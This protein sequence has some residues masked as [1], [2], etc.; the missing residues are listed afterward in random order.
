MRIA[1]ACYDFTGV[2]NTF[3]RAHVDRLSDASCVIA[4]GLPRPLNQ[5]ILATLWRSAPKT[6]MAALSGKKPTR[7]L[8]YAAALSALQQ[9]KPSVVLAEFGPTAVL[10]LE[11]CE[12]LEIP[13]VAHFHGYDI[14]RRS[15]LKTYAAD[16]K[17]LFQ[18]ASGIIGVS[19]EMCDKLVELGA[20]REKVT[21]IACGVDCQKFKFHD[22]SQSA[23]ILLYVGRFT[24][25]K[26]PAGVLRAFAKTKQEVAAAKL[27]MIGDGPLLESCRQLAKEL[28]VRDSVDFTGAQNSKFVQQQMSNVRALVQFSTEAP[29]GDREGTP[30]VILEAGASGLPVIGS[31]HG[32]ILDVIQD[33]ETGLLVSE[34]DENELSNAMARL[35]SQPGVCGRMG[36]HASERIRR[37]YDLENVITQLYD[38]L[39]SAV[40]NS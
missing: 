5:S 34:N 12:E 39:A 8:A 30:V 18:Y 36:R 26:N 29:D 25:K 1:I 37:D 9:V 33:K 14:S 28:R 35:L 2:S 15:T 4:G 16:Y 32:G 31:R 17:R 7:A 27:T 23:P 19:Q 13:L 21:H 3:I 38:V 6:A 40:R 20:S 22:A 10:M 11:P 24:P